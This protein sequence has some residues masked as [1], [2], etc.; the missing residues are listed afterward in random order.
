MRY[1]FW[2]HN[3]VR[4]V[5]PF[6]HIRPAWFYLPVVLA[7]LFP[8][9]LLAFWFIRFL[10]SGD[11]RRSRLRTPEFGFHLLAGCWCVAFFSMA[12]SKLPTYILPAFPLLGLAVGVYAAHRVPRVTAVMIGAAFVGLA[13]IHFAVIPWYAGFGRRWG[14]EKKSRSIAATR[15]SRS[16]VSRGRATRWRF[17]WGAAI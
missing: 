7:G 9:T 4:L 12:G 5:Q 6:D 17:I 10:L 3:V 16:W 8:A 11:P 15:I 1:F 13:A 2:D 14:S